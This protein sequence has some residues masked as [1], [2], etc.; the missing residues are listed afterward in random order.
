MILAAVVRVSPIPSTLNF[1]S[2]ISTNAL[3]VLHDSHERDLDHLHP[4]WR[5]PAPVELNPLPDRNHDAPELD[6]ATD[7]RWR[8]HH[9]ED[10]YRVL[11][12]QIAVADTVA[13]GAADG[14]VSFHG[15]AE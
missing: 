5:L 10:L 3:Q 2:Q 1:L 11:D 6:L 15:L 8:P 12:L 13:Y 7:V 9:G 4:R 14:A